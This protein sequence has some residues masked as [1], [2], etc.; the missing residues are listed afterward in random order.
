LNILL[1]WVTMA[2]VRRFAVKERLKVGEPIPYARPPQPAP[3]E[4]P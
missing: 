3:V 1:I 2:I 4:Q